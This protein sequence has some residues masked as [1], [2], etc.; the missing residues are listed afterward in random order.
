MT[1]LDYASE[2]LDPRGTRLDRVFFRVAKICAILPMAIGLTILVLYYFFDWDFLVPVGGLMLFVGTFIILTGIGLTITWCIRQYFAAKRLGIP[3][4]WRT[5]VFLT[6]LLLANFPVAFFCLA[7]G[8]YLVDSHVSVC[9][10][11]ETADDLTN[12]T[13]RAAWFSRSIG[14]I[15]PGNSRY[16]DIR[17]TH[18]NVIRIRVE[19]A[20]DSKELATPTPSHKDYLLKTHVKPGLELESEFVYWSR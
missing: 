17:P 7:V 13:V 2:S 16:V 6:F 14:T 1:H 10:S 18:S 12:V 4:R 8:G 15:R 5:G 11:N 3:V 20:G 9:V 19:Q